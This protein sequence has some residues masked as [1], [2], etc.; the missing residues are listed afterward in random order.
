MSIFIYIIASSMP[1]GLLHIYTLD[2]GQGDSFLIQTPEG[3]HI[4][5]DAGAD[6]TKIIEELQENMPWYKK[7]L[8][9]AIISH[10]DKD[11]YF[12]FWEVMKKYPPQTLCIGSIIRDGEYKEFIESAKKKSK[13]IFLSHDKDFMIEKD[14]LLETLLP[15][16]KK[17]NQYYD[18]INDGSIIQKLKY[19]NISMLFTGDLEV[20]G[21]QLLTQIY[22]EYLKSDIL[23]VS[24][25]GAKNGTNQKLLKA[26]QPKYAIISA[27]VNNRYNHP[28]PNTIDF[29]EK[30]N[31]QYFDTIQFKNIE[32][33]SDGNFIEI[34]Y[35][36]IQ[37]EI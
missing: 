14:M 12:G 36:P 2:I 32:I 35:L 6:A 11:H 13:I 30:N 4:L 33:I 34:K 31:I 3:K 28:H 5:I 7:S 20:D 1:D 10:P 37:K 26:V 21:I 24:H 22:Q 29:L 8:D 17:T 23:K 16:L 25:H 18:N 9:I 19:K 27:G 15:L